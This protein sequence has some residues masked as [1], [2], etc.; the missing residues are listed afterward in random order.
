MDHG[1]TDHAPRA[2]SA[3]QTVAN[4]ERAVGHAV[5]VQEPYVREGR[6]EYACSIVVQ[7]EVEFESD[8]MSRARRMRDT[9]TPRA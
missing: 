8:E 7:D 1:C 3:P 6:N 5:D 9:S 2:T 4:I